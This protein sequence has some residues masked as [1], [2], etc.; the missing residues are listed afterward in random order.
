MSIFFHILSHNIIPIFLLISLGFLLSKKFDLHIFSLSKLMFY[1]FVPAFIFVNLYTT[2]LKLSML[3]V[4]LCGV[5][6]LITND[7]IARIIAKIRNYDVGL[8]NAFKNSIMFNNSGNIGV[9]LI[10]LVFGSAPFVIDGKMPYL[11]EAI[12]AQIIILVIQNISVN[13]VGFF[14]A[15]RANSSKK[16]SVKTILK[17]PSIYAI[18]LALFLKSIQ[19]DIT[20]TPFWPTLEYLKSGLVPMALITLGVQ[21]SK[22]NFD[23]KNVD[24][25]LSVFIKLIIGPLLALSYIHLLGL[26]GV[27]AQA[28][29]IAH[30]VPTAVNTAL[31]AVECDSCS[32]FASQAVMLSTLFSAITLTLAIYAAQFLFPA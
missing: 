13:T 14:N 10:T 17:M 6:M 20:T 4:L 19:L 23:L 1:L 27:V 24:V 30:A 16:D 29:F 21:L 31:I 2:D 22:T 28:V 9:S 25:H 15:G 7:M 5:L 8:T 12:T 26:T 3:K 18:P 32:D 11:N